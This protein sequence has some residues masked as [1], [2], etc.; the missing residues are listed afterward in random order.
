MTSQRERSET[1]PDDPAPE[2]P[3]HS[4]ARLVAAHHEGRGLRRIR[5]DPAVPLEFV[6]GQVAALR[7]AGA[8]PAYFAIASAPHEPGP[9][10]FLIKDGGEG[11]S[12]RALLEAPL[13]TALELD[14]PLG[15]GFDLDGSD[16]A[17]VLLVGAGTGIAPLRSVLAELL[18][19]PGRTGG[20]ALVH[21][22]RFADQRCFADEHARWEAAGVRLRVVVSRPSERDGW[23]GLVGRVQSHIEDLVT[24]RSLVFIA[25]MDEMLAET[26]AALVELG[27]EPSR[28][29]TNLE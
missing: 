24:P 3:T 1:S 6:P 25:G 2:S 12:S 29:R 11:S 14:A 21:G 5:V 9:L 23:R 18:V 4:D 19:T 10:S 7:V 13:G 22:V 8:D 20:I 27:V 17:D 28:I 16:D 15:A 26:R